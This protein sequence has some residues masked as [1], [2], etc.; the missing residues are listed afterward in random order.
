[1]SSRTPSALAED[2]VDL[3]RGLVRIDTTNT[4]DPDTTVG[5]ALAAEFAQSALQEA[6]YEPERF[7]T[8]HAN[9]QGIHLRIPG[10]D[11]DRPALLLHGHLDV[12]PAHAADW[13]VDPFAAEIADGMLW[14]R[15]AVDMKDMVAMMLAVVRGWAGT[16]YRPPR[17][18]VL[19]LTPDEEAGGVRGSHWLVDH[20]RHFFDGVAEAVGEVG[21]FSLTLARQRLY[22]MQV[23]EKGIAWLRLTA[24]GRAGHGSMVNHDNAVTKLAGALMSLDRA[25]MPVR[26]TATMASFI[27]HLSEATGEHFD[28]LE[29]AAVLARLGPLAD[30]IAPGFRNTVNPTMLQAGYKTNV[31]PGA[32]SAVVD[33]RFL[34]GMEEELLAS[35]RSAVGPGIDVE[36]LHR[37]VAV[38]TAFEGPLVDAIG[39]ALREEDPTARVVPYLMSGGT[40]GKAFSRLGIR[41]FGFAPLQ[42]PPDLDFAAL[43]H[44]VDE[45]VPIEGLQFGARVMD[46]FL[47]RC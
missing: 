40:D 4:G 7:E 28:A 45:R 41:C 35:V 16:G 42:L 6:G 24:R 17:D 12:V 31:I 29:P 25:P 23:A 20:R 5:E 22:F 19:L 13:R 18:V 43:F 44:G 11:P 9:R 14:G 2:V 8:T 10:T 26:P 33:G 37:D 39:T 1:M 15:G 21:G 27:E 46:R 47:R 32:A 34:P 3:C 36:V 38:E 30:M